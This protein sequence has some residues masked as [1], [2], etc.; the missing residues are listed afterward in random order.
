MTIIY[1]YIAHSTSLESFKSPSENDHVDQPV[2]S[3]QDV[4]HESNKAAD[5][6]KPSI[7]VLPNYETIGIVSYTKYFS[8][9]M[10]VFVLD[11]EAETPR[12]QH[13]AAVR[14][15]GKNVIA[16]YKVSVVLIDTCTIGPQLFESPLSE[17]LIIPT[18]N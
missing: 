13:P 11:C 17:P 7:L 9:L 12:T 1:L 4:Q 3:K 2:T 8:R 10:V 5:T 14:P 16:N 18:L 6:K 15:L